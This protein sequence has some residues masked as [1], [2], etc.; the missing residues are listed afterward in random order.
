MA[1][2]ID[3]TNGINDIVLG[4]STP[5]AA[6]VTTLGFTSL[7]GTG[8][9]AITDILD[10]DN[11]AS[12]S[13]TKLATQ[14]SIKAYVD[15]QVDTADTLAEV[16]AIG[17]TSGGTDLAISAGDDITFI[18]NSKAIFGTGSDLQIFSDGTNSKIIES[19]SG[20]LLIGADNNITF[21]NAAVNEN[22]AI[23]TTNGGVT[24]YYDNVIKFATTT[25]GV[26]VTGGTTSVGTGGVTIDATADAAAN[27]ELE[28]TAVARQFNT[29]VGGA[30]FATTALR[31]SYYI[32]DATATAYRFSINSSGLV[33]IGTTAP[34]GA[35]LHV[36]GASNQ[37]IRVENSSNNSRLSFVDSGTSADTAL[38]GSNSGGFEWYTASA[39]R[40]SLKSD[41]KLGIGTANPGQPLE[42][43]TGNGS[44]GIRINRFGSGVYY[45]DIVHADTPERLA[46]KVGT[47]AAIAERMAITGAGNLLLNDSANANSVRLNVR[48]T[49]SNHVVEVDLNSTNALYGIMFTNPN[50]TVGNITVSG[51]TTAF[52]TS[53]DYRLKENVSYSF[54]ATTRL[55][56]LKPAR[57]NFIADADSTVDGFLAHEVAEVVPE[58]ITGTKDEVDDEGKPVMQ[59]IDQGKLV[60]LLVKTI[61]EL[62]ARITALE[63]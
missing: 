16:L 25:T 43:F 14:Q 41:G 17:N 49:G 44:N 7:S 40:M 52:N 5:A 23:F 13:A 10:E 46:F 51:S 58:A 62:E 42:V 22:K 24:L 37:T 39:L 36:S 8:A 28:L 34:T 15:T 29:G 31:G 55:K 61:L 56:K 54:D 53:S 32:Y 2:T 60:P 18:D 35:A 38:F 9:V 45:S 57:F 3:G 47:G 27:P 30:T 4:S 63:G 19:G 11:M 20:D 6:T 50:G 26:T 33:G 59:G 1:V 21:T 48:G 12:N